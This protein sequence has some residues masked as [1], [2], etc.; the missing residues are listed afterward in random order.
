VLDEAGWPAGL[1]EA[2]WPA[3]LD[4]AGWPAGLD[5]AG[6]AGDMLDE[7]IAQLVEAW[8]Q[9]RSYVV[10]VSDETG[11]GVVPETPAGRM[12]RD[13]LGRVNQALAA[14]SEQ[15]ELVVAGLVVSLGG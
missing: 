3:G 8:R 5:E 9:A 14:E 4:E 10:A 7:R 15:T 11:L 1:D 13:W 2:G 6:W 12:F